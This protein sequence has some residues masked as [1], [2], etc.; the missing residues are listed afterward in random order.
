MVNDNI[1]GAVLADVDSTW[2]AFHALDGMRID[3]NEV[4]SLDQQKFKQSLRKHILDQFEGKESVLD[5][6]SIQGFIDFHNVT[7]RKTV[8]RCVLLAIKEGL[9]VPYPYEA[10]KFC[11]HPVIGFEHNRS[12]WGS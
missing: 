8:A 4:C 12:K 6:F 11:V 2:T 10:G 1:G 9:M 7:D 5:L 3:K